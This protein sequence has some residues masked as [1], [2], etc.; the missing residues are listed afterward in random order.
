MRSVAC[1]LGVESR[2]NWQVTT[3]RHSKHVEP[4]RPMHTYLQVFSMF[5]GLSMSFRILLT[6]RTDCSPRI[7]DCA[8]VSVLV[9][10]CTSC[11]CSS[12]RAR[13]LVLECSC[14]SALVL[15]RARRASY[16]GRPIRH[17]FT[18]LW[19]FCFL[20]RLLLL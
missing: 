15:V 1:A 6:A 9:L 12:A 17:K 20:F 18:F 13:V 14:S 8:R 7:L 10:E 11:S 5:D 4:T 16:V 2:E 19:L 3:G